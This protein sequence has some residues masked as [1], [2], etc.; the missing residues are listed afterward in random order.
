[1]KEKILYFSNILL[2]FVFLFA[3]VNIPNE[4]NTS[5]IK[6]ISEKEATTFLL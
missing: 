4:A 3:L 1:M 2:L 6:Q 5:N